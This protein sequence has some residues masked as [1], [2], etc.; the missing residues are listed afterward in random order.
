M[1]REWKQ[2]SWR[3]RGAITGLSV[4]P[5]LASRPCARDPSRILSACRHV[6]APAPRA[7]SVAFAS[8]ER[9]AS[10][11]AAPRAVARWLRR[12][13]PTRRPPVRPCVCRGQGRLGH[14]N[15]RHATATGR[16]SMSTAGTTSSQER[17]T[18]RA[19]PFQSTYSKYDATST[20]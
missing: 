3:P 4:S 2:Y 18:R 13:M 6:G 14:R 5:S 20:C 10:G 19:V 1:N 12:H 8:R 9:G 15:G 17:T 7:Y 11:A 16:W